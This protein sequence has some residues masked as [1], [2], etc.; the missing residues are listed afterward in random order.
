MA[1]IRLDMRM[2]LA[3]R[4]NTAFRVYENDVVLI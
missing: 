4:I 1:A 3:Y 2:Q